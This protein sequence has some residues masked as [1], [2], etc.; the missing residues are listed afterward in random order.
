MSD[1]KPL[2]SL[3]A[4]ALIAVLS[5]LRPT[6]AADA[7]PANCGFTRALRIIESVEVVRTNLASLNRIHGISLSPILSRPPGNPVL[8]TSL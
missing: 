6:A 2:A 3:A 1:L 4:A 5:P 8:N 7:R